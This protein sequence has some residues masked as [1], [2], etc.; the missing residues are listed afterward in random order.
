MKIETNAIDVSKWLRGVS[1]NQIPFA[2]AL[3]IT[4]TAQVIKKN[5][6][7]E[8]SQKFD[9]PTPYTLNSL[10]LTAAK[11]KRLEAVVWLRDTT[12][13]KSTP[14]TKYIGPQVHGGARNLK[15]FERALQRTGILPAGMYAVPGEG[16]TMDAFGNMSRGQIV[17]ILSYF[18]A[19]GEQGYTANSTVKTRAK[20]AKGTKKKRGIE[21]F[22]VRAGNRGLTPGIYQRTRFVFGAAIKPVLI[23][24]RSPA[25][26]RRLDF[27]GIANKT[28]ADEAPAQFERAYAD[29]MRTAR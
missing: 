24:V 2:T 29:A 16:A 26:A 11:P 28:F 13:G 15:R 12:A 25:Y 7:N 19:F 4:R 27:F 8:M 14:A 20:L 18:Q 23:F 9:R 17:K 6:L 10:Y 1:G 22:V 21:Y 5:I 3:G